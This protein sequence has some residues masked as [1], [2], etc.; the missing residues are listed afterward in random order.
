MLKLPVPK[1]T[2]QLRSERKARSARRAEKRAKAAAAEASAAA[3]A[4]SE[5]LANGH[6]PEASTQEVQMEVDTSTAA[7]GIPNGELNAA[8]QS[9]EAQKPD[10]DASQAAEDGQQDDFAGEDE[11]PILPYTWEDQ[12]LYTMTLEKMQKKLYYDGYLSVSMFLED[13]AKIIHNAGEAKSV[14]AE[15]FV[16]AGQMQNL[17]NVLL[18]QSVDPAFKAECEAMAIRQRA[19]DAKARE[20]AVEHPPHSARRSFSHPQGPERHSSRI[21]GEQP[22]HRMPVDVAMIEREERKRARHSD[23]DKSESQ[24]DQGRSKRVRV[25]DG[26][27]DEHEAETAS[28]APQSST[29]GGGHVT[30]RPPQPPTSATTLS[31][32]ADSQ[33]MAPALDQA[34]VNGTGAVQTQFSD[35]SI[36]RNSGPVLPLV[37]GMDPSSDRLA[38]ASA[39]TVGTAEEHAMEAND[40]MV[41]TTH[42]SS[43]SGGAPAAVP[44]LASV[45][46]TTSEPQREPTL[47]SPVSHPPFQLDEAWLNHSRT[48]L[49]VETSDLSIEDLERLRAAYFDVIW[50][51][52]SLWNRDTV[53]AQCWEA[54]AA[55]LKQFRQRQMH[56]HHGT[57]VHID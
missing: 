10:E 37:D 45:S 19:R 5:P 18:E 39:S 32:P 42:A 33:P 57:T 3:D 16:K 15:R 21:A 4:Q 22:E 25:Q 13:L 48:A 1:T 35:D 56:P 26:V 47:E 20:E 44:A 29:A 23:S 40:V 46:Q 49:A 54:K 53:I 9:A 27:T 7:S 8:V 11:E 31:H 12:T 2:E 51:T 34:V 14:D 24:D 52:R 43:T 55:F 36:R 41:S 30:A 38:L 17:A 28:A 50:R 6:G